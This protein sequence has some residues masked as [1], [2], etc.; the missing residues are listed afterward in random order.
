M[1]CAVSYL[2]YTRGDL[3]QKITVMGDDQD[4]ALECRQ[5]LFDGLTWSE[6]PCDWL[7]RP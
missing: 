5:A 1:E 2:Y 7:V 4:R 6:Y 3:V